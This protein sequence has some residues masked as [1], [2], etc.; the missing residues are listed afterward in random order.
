MAK[1]NTAS[2]NTNFEFPR[3]DVPKREK[4]EKY[5]KNFVQA[6]INESIGNNYD[7]DYALMD[8]AVNFFNGDQ[9]G[10][11]FD[12]L[13]SAEDGEVLPAK[14]ANYNRI[15][16]RVETTIGEYTSRA[17]KINA[18]S[19]NKDAKSRKLKAKLGAM[20]DMNLSPA[21]QEIEDAVGI[22][23]DNGRKKFNSEE[24]VNDHFKYNFKE[25]NELI[26][27]R[28]LRWLA[29]KNNWIYQKLAA[30]RDLRI[31][32]RTFYKTEIVDGLPFSKRVDPRF[33]IFD[34]SA[35]DD[36]LSDAAFWGEISYMTLADASSKFNLSQGEIE[37][38][39]GHWQDEQRLGRAG[40][41][42][43]SFAGLSD[44]NLQYFKD[45]GNDLRV[46]VVTGY[47]QDQEV[48]AHRETVDKKGVEHIK[49]V[50]DEAESGNIRRNTI[51]QW[52]QGTIIGGNL[53]KDWG[54]V[55]N[56]V[57]DNESLAE[58][59][60]P[61]KGCAPG[62]LNGRSVS[63]TEQLMSLQKL[64][65][66][67]LYNLTLE[68]STS[69]RKGF[70]YDTA[71]TPKNWDVHKVLKYLKTAGVAFIDSA[72]SGQPSTYNQFG[73]IDQTLGGSVEQYI[74]ISMMIDAEMDAI[75]GI[76]YA[77]Q[78]QSTGA[79]QG[80]G[81]TQTAL[82]QSSM[83]TRTVD[84]IF[85]MLNEQVLNYQAGLVKLSFAGNE[86]YS[87]IIGDDGVDLLEDIM[88]LELDDFGIFLE[89]VPPILDDLQSFRA[90]VEAALSS[91]GLTFP[92]AA[93]LLIEKDIVVA[94][95]RLER[96]I[97]KNEEKA[98]KMQQMQTEQAQ[99]GAQAAQAQ[100]E[101]SER[102]K[103]ELTNQ[104][105]IQAAQTVGDYS[106]QDRRIDGKQNIDEIL[107]KG[108]VDAKS[109]FKEFGY[110]SKL[111][112]LKDNADARRETSKVTGKK[113]N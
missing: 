45:D 32:G 58:T 15:K 30:Y 8:E 9:G 63:T 56:S 72:K 41:S 108:R 12:F 91:G 104:G 51:S 11:E 20:V 60:C 71:Q 49:Q 13:Q 103:I 7:L 10:E 69:G 97:A 95:E 26:V 29:K 65:D 19:I 74:R 54:I 93:R 84:D 83:S 85:N 70:V 67:T 100:K 98:M 62:W 99:A 106:I 5:H 24:E 21:R 112:T 14:W 76:N 102:G 109:D 4:N 25:R 17:T 52:R 86:R 66:L 46:L 57:R 73:Q 22:S 50:G 40:A 92:Q 75:S 105:R 78:G 44:S 16:V 61:I 48:I 33:I 42:G 81:V 111:Q 28:S 43:M 68:M 35:T 6:I 53:I 113:Q 31:M 59:S 34:G 80:L 3:T 94:V 38:V 82:M 55:E 96:D 37:E 18:R 77:R 2:L 64:K 1:S 110:D 88:D 89:E 90:I 27:E 47:W 101:E 39:Y 23:L 79:N 36:F 107:A 87:P